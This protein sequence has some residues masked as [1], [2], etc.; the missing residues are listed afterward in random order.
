MA[1]D[2]IA[3]KNDCDLTLRL[4]ELF[5]EYVTLYTKLYKDGGENSGVPDERIEMA[6][7]LESANQEMSELVLQ[8][9][10]LQSEET[11]ENVAPQTI[12]ASK[13]SSRAYSSV[14]A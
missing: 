4:Q 8:L 3:D 10:N 9:Q 13:I 5:R 12:S 14:G 1:T 7:K 6:L 2:K 11:L